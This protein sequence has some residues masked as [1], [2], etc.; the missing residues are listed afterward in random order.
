MEAAALHS[1]KLPT[2]IISGFHIAIAL[3]AHDI[4]HA[5]LHTWVSV[6]TLDGDIGTMHCH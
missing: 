5:S 1:T 6:V 4:V 3:M 2:C